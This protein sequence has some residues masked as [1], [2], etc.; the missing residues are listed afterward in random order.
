MAVTVLLAGLFAGELCAQTSQASADGTEKDAIAVVLGKKLTVKDKDK[1]N[2][3]IFGPLLEKFAK[4]NKIEPTEEE[5]DAFILHQG[6]RS[7]IHQHPL[8]DDGRPSGKIREH[9]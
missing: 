2:G 8:V 7:E 4:D 5:L 3:L 9:Y 6:R 1:L